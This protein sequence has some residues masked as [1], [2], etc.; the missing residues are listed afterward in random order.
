[1]L[2]SGGRKLEPA[3][4][5]LYRSINAGRNHNGINIGRYRAFGGNSS[6]WGG[7]LLPFFPIDFE[8]REWVHGSGWPINFNRVKPYYAK[9]LDFE[10]LSA[11]LRHDDEVWAAVGMKPPHLGTELGLHFSRWCPQ[12]DF[13]VLHGREIERS[14]ALRC[15]LHTTVTAFSCRED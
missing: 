6:Q 1:L 7:Q 12:P 5:D 10:G 3:L 8:K 15:I 2:E 11:C 4:Q 9:A 13:A 14:A